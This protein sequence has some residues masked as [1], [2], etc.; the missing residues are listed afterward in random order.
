ML[1][2]VEL[3]SVDPIQL[4]G[5][6]YTVDNADWLTMLGLWINYSDVTVTCIAY[7]AV[8]YWLTVICSNFKFPWSYYTIFALTVAWQSSENKHFVFQ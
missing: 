5:C 4:N 2:Q 7:E 6:G 3:G 1:H 8:Q